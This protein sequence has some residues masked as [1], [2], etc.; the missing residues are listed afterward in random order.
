MCST[1][2]VRPSWAKRGVDLFFVLSGFLITTILLQSKPGDWGEIRRF[3]IRRTLRIFPLYYGFLAVSSL[4]GAAI[5]IW[6]WIYL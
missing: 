6:F 1:H 4:V 2:C 5:S 3:Y